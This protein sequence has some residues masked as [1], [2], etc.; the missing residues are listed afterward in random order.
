MNKS[1]SREQQWRTLK[2][3]QDDEYEHALQID[4]KNEIEHKRNEKENVDRDIA[5]EMK[6]RHREK[7]TIYRNRLQ[8]P[9][10][11]YDISM[12]DASDLVT[13]KFILP[14]NNKS[15]IHTFHKDE[16]MFILTSQ[17]KYDLKYIDPYPLILTTF[18]NVVCKYNRRTLIGDTDL[19]NNVVHVNYNVPDEM[20]FTWDSDDDIGV[21]SP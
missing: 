21:W 16:K 12:A 13:I 8:P 15:I 10:Y 2:Q 14:P 5:I 3:E 9:Q 1:L 18:P 17:L 6:N 7:D 11:K 20:I 4:M 19:K